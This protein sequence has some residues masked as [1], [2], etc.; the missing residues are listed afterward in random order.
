MSISDVQIQD[1]IEAQ[2]QE[3]EKRNDDG[4][5]DGEDEEEINEQI[6]LPLIW[7]LITNNDLLRREYNDL[8]RREYDLG[9]KK[10]ELD[11]R[12]IGLS[13]KE[14]DIELR[15]DELNENLGKLM[16][17][18]RKVLKNMEHVNYMHKRAEDAGMVALKLR[19]EASDNLQVVNEHLTS[20][21]YHTEE[22][23]NTT[24]DEVANEDEAA[25]TVC[26]TNKLRLAPGCG[27]LCMCRECAA[28]I[29]TKDGRKCPICRQSWNSL[30]KIIIS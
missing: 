3:D 7:P 5:D 22:V 18:K 12:E 24:T 2:I 20:M 26:F 28:Y 13:L 29:H 23:L 6:L 16:R 17:D 21:I 27:H 19:Q 25:C 11:S 1:I 15:E 9:I 4:E 10:I 14:N 30:T 8:L